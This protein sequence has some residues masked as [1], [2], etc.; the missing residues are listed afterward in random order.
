MEAIVLAGGFGTRLRNVISNLPKS[1]APIKD[2]PF[3]ERLLDLLAAKGFKR[4]ILSLGWMADKIFSYFGNSYA[5]MALIYVIEDIPLDTG[6][7]IKK[8][9]A[10]CENDHVFV[11]NGDTYLDLEVTHV[12]SY[13]RLHK[14]P[15]IIA[16]EVTDASRYGCI[17]VTKE[18]QIVEFS[19][20][21]NS[22]KGLINAGCY[23][24]PTNIFHTY[25]GNI[26]SLEKDFLPLMI[27]KQRTNVFITT[28]YFIDI[29]IPDDYARAQLELE[30]RD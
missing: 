23:V 11:F 24:L 2:K 19:E 10:H 29:G 4:I 6:G 7:A 20:K 8:A 12:E 21:G 16:H 30:F 1:M 27:K 28:G 17:K 26:F 22:G 9:I 25:D 18:N 5:G 3:L 15:I 14:G 13:F